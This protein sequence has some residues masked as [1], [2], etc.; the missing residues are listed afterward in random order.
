MGK[1]IDLSGKRF[2][3]LTVIEK[4]G[5]NAKGI[6]IWRCAC[7]CGHC[8]TVRSDDL[9]C[10]KVKSCGCFKKTG[11]H[12]SHGGTYTRLYRVWCSM[13]ARCKNPNNEDYHNYGGRGIC[14]CDDWLTDYS[15]F[16]DW[17][18]ANGYAVGLTIDRIDNDGNYQPENCRWVTMKVQNN[19]KKRK[20]KDN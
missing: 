10:G 14:V 19:N 13:R 4:V 8:T 15:A 1:L 16:R 20:K 3:M 9:R 5:T 18:E 12:K 6:A 2:G 11:L 17:S 7:D